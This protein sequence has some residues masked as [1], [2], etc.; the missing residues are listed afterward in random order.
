MADSHSRYR[1]IIC[2]EDQ[3]PD[4]VDA[5]FRFRKQLFVDTLGWQLATDGERERDQFDHEFAIHCGLYHDE[6]LIGG[7]RAIRCDHDY[8]A[9]SV[10]GSLA[11]IRTLPQRRDM[12]EISRFG[13]L[14]TLTRFD[15]ARLTYAV[16]FRFA[17]L[18]R[19]NALVAI[20]D[21][22]HERFLGVLGIRTRRYGP[23]QTIGN[24]SF[25]RPITVV[26]GDIP[27]DEQD[28]PRFQ[29]VMRAGYAVEVHDET[30]VFGSER[31]SA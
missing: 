21:L 6:A 9:R 12:W 29:R 18:H 11:T 13:I 10:F 25:G 24:D 22:S 2:T 5:L 19:A 16:M 26:V 28:G 4:A 31:I 15:C 3:S 30:L 17:K 27:L 20:T 14:P 8:L 7:F 23:P 1:A